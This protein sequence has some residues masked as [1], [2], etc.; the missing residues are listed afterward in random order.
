M[1]WG[2]RWIA[3]LTTL[4]AFSIAWS[5]PLSARTEAAEPAS[6]PNVKE[7]LD[8]ARI[9]V[10]RNK[11]LPGLAYDVLRDIPRLQLKAGNVDDALA[12]IAELSPGYSE[13]I[14]IEIAEALARAGRRKDAERVMQ[15]VEPHYC[16]DEDRTVGRTYLDDQVRSAFLDFQLANGDFSGAR[17]TAAEVTTPWLRPLVWQKLGVAYAKARDRAMSQQSFRDAVSAAAPIPSKKNPDGAYL[18][19]RALW[20]IADAQFEAQ[21]RHGAAETLQRLTQAASTIKDGLDR[22]WALYSAA[23]REARLGDHSTAKRLFRQAVA[24]CDE[25]KPPTPCPE[26]NRILCLQRIAKAQA[27]AGYYDEAMK[28]A[29]S[30][31]K[32]KSEALEAIADV[33][34]ARA[35]NGDVPGAVVTALSLESDSWG[36]TDALV[37]IVAIQIQRHDPRGAIQ[38]SEK[39]GRR[40]ER[41]IASLK[42]AAEFARTGDSKSAEITAGCIRLSSRLWDSDRPEKIFDYQQPGTWGRIYDQSRAFTSMSYQ[43]QVNRAANLGAAALTLSQVLRKRY[44]VS[45]AILFAD[46]DARVVRALARAQAAIGAPDEALAWS[47]QIGSPEV[48]KSNH[49]WR[50][51]LPVEQRVAALLGTA[52]GILERQGRLKN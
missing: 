42:I 43:G 45:Y 47:R 36:R 37:A 12:A 24:T 34:K 25:I 21:D 41:T 30:I 9:I 19:G 48:R 22:A 1:R 51:G 20:E 14:R 10:V 40:L 50:D 29:R 32:D 26:A 16:C 49:E 11:K 6:A 3:R 15:A 31:P 8:E 46:F 7:I 28:T 17:H 18:D 13:P 5:L 35:K 23:E 44:P 52:E 38:T 4:L 33:A 39:I 27:E 2:T